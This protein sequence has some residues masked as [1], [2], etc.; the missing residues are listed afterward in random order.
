MKSEIEKVLFSQPSLVKC[1]QNLDLCLI[2]DCTASM[3]SWIKRAKDTINEIIDNIIT[4]NPGIKI[5]VAFVGYRDINDSRRFEV[6]EFSSDV[7]A[8]KLFI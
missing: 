7:H 1:D 4:Q 3:G 5:N 2:L 8:V 6:C